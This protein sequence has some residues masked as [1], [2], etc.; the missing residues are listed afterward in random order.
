[1]RMS[2]LIGPATLA[3]GLVAGASMASAADAAKG[4]ELYHKYQCSSCHG[5]VGQGANTGP[6]LAP[7]PLPLDAMMNFVRNSTGL[8]PA[9]TATILKDAEFADIHAY[10]ASIPKTADYKT[11]PLLNAI[12]Q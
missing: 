11:I 9:Y 3:A 10:L 6:K 5:G 4:K 2:K 1:M 8:M 12:T 7:E